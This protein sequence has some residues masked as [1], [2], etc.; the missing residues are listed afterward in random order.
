M[1]SVRKPPAAFGMDD[2]DRPACDDM[3]SKMQ[4][5]A[6]LSQKQSVAKPP[7][8]DDCPVTSGILGDASWKLLHT[9]VRLL[10]VFLEYLLMNE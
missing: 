6:S 4:Q 7:A 8:E 2:C 9:M 3:M 10:F 5:A 1:P